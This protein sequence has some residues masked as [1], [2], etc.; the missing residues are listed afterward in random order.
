MKREDIEKLLK[1]NGIA[2][3]KMKTVLDNIL[4]ENGK[5][6]EA[7][8]AKTT[9]KDGELVKAN[10]TIKELQAAVKKFDGVDIDKLRKMPRICS[11]SMILIS[12]QNRKRLRI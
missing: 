9:A 7:E 5:D 1:E 3:D 4:D 8:K 12:L 2:E 11:R 6:I 10:G